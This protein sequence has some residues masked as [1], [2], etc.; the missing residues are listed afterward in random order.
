LGRFELPDKQVDGVA[1][2][3]EGAANRRR[4]PPVRHND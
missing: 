2:A 3:L 4:Q 1:L